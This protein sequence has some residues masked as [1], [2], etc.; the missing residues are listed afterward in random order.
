MTNPMG[1]G[2]RVLMGA[3]GAALAIASLYA[4]FYE[5]RTPAWYTVPNILVLVVCCVLG[6]TLFIS[7][8]MEEK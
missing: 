2:E 3:V 6:I 8:V 4:M 1:K 7:S 5:G